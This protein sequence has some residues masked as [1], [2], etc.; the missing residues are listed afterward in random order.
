M[1]AY[2]QGIITAEEI[3]LEEFPEYYQCVVIEPLSGA[4]PIYK[5]ETLEKL[6]KRGSLAYA[7]RQ[8]LF[9]NIVNTVNC[10]HILGVPH[11][12]LT[13]TNILIENGSLIFLK[14]FFIQPCATVE[15]SWYLSP[16]ETFECRS[17]TIAADVWAL[18]CIFCEVF[19]SLT[20][21]FQSA[22]VSE[23]ITKIFQCLGVP[24]FAEVADYMSR[25]LYETFTSGVYI[26][27]PYHEQLFGNLPVNEYSMLTGMLSFDPAI[28]PSCK[29]LLE[30]YILGQSEERP[31]QPLL[32]DTSNSN[33]ADSISYIDTSSI[34]AIDKPEN[35]PPTVTKLHD[36][37][38]K[39]HDS[40]LASTNKNLEQTNSDLP[41]IT[42]L[43]QM[44]QM[45]QTPQIEPDNRLIIRLITARNFP[46]Y[47]HTDKV[48]FECDVMSDGKVRKMLTDPQKISNKIELDFT[49]SL[50]I[51]SSAFS[52][53]QKNR[54]LV[55]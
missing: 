7:Q 47:S 41:I 16:E 4:N 48:V 5:A 12:N 42:S 32:Q 43:S 55:I 19:V 29:E 52:E 2:Q 17:L 26:D 1:R 21:L 14:A 35:I 33:L 15:N 45:P 31:F 22:E 46:L 39:I 24:P 9:Q 8:R 3:Y 13:P 50:R 40:K 27:K 37:S 34:L 6:L 11:L 54:P 20:P 36:D 51:N 44:S 28:R 49:D 10:L 23:K 25:H 30:S 53:M 38:I 18:G